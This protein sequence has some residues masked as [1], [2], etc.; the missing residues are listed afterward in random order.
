M[1]VQVQTES[2]GGA[3]ATS[4][5]VTEAALQALQYSA[6]SEN[7]ERDSANSERD[8]LRLF[9]TN[10]MKVAPALPLLAALFA[11]VSLV[12]T[13]WLH[14][15]AWLI[16]A[17]GCQIIQYRLCQLYLASDRVQHRQS[18]WL[19]MIAASEFLTGACWSL[20]LFLFWNS[21][22]D[23]QHLYIVATMMAVIALRI[24]IAA[25]FLPII[26]A[27]TGM[28]TFNVVVRC[29]LES[30]A[31]YFGL[32]TMAI[33]MQIIFILVAR[34]LQETASDMLI[35]KAQKERLIAQL[36]E[37]RDRAENALS[38]A[39]D[40][41]ARAEEAN[42]AKS[43][44]LATMSHELRTPLN[45]ILGFSE[46][47]SQEMFGK[48][49]NETYKLYADDIHKSGNYLLNLIND[50]LDLSRIE[51]G[52]RELKDEPISLAQSFQEAL[53]FIDMRLKDK[54]ITVT[55]NMPND[56]PKIMA[57]RRALQQVWLN[58]LSNAAKFTPH[59]GEIGVGARR[60]DDGGLTVSVT[61][62][63]PGIPENELK[64]ALGAFSRGSFALKQAIEGAGLGLAITKGLMTQHD[65]DLDL[66]SEM[67][68]GTEALITF[69]AAR[70]L[71]GPRG[72]V[73]HEPEGATITQ[74]RLIAATR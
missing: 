55:N 22:N 49:R 63:G 9:I 42:K 10:Q 30:D 74:L 1:S 69:P 14:A 66:K 12:W 52:R 61:D 71:T 2:G 67:G 70:V 21:A 54:A 65:G 29:L 48:H 15:A 34:R 17:C 26:I 3:S 47:L 27:G 72:D 19:G 45:A 35:F 46:V 58:L 23:F 37:E 53:G 24:M 8:L 5:A 39:E 32:G 28:M 41:K 44:F 16:A 38:D 7:E 4:H 43:Q 6:R 11:L 57:D 33:G 64:L 18:E 68:R 36:R 20:P 62:N 59:G 60:L 51:A 73:A 25:N 13:P 31:L 50:I 40:A 56:L